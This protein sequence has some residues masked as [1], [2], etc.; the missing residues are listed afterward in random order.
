MIVSHEHD[1]DPRY[2][3]ASINIGEKKSALIVVH[4]DE[5]GSLG[6]RF[7]DGE[8]RPT[9]ICASRTASGCS[10]PNVSIEG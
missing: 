8:M 4:S 6:F 3:W 1:Q 9:C 5:H 2:G 7:E 10:C